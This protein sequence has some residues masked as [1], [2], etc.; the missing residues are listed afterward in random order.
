MAV[1]KQLLKKDYF[2]VM[3]L[4]AIWF[5]IF[6][7]KFNVKCNVGHYLDPHNFVDNLFSSTFD[8][9]GVCD[10]FFSMLNSSFAIVQLIIGLTHVILVWDYTTL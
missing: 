3:P 7:V 4:D 1:E 8:H 6:Y 5:Y 2:P 10:I 9:W